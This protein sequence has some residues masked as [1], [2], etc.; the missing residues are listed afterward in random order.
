MAK[1]VVKWAMSPNGNILMIGKQPTDEKEPFKPEHE[2]DLTIIFSGITEMTDVQKN[3]VIYGTKQKL[4]D[5][6]AGEKADAEAKIANAKAKWD[7]LVAGKWT[8]ERINATGNAE[9]KRLANMVKE[10]SQVVSLEGLVMKKMTFPDKFTEADEAKLQ[11]FLREV[12]RL[13][14]KPAKK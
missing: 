13:Q 10:A 1:R 7:E 8:G 5:V 11:E 14:A 3:L 4:M 12:A 2:F 6:G 9:N